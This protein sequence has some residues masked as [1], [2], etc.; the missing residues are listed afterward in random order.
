MAIVSSIVADGYR[1]LQGPIEGTQTVDPTVMLMTILGLV[2]RCWKVDSQLRNL[3]ADLERDTLSPL[4]WPELSSTEIESL[5]DDPKFGKVF[6]VS[7]KFSNIR[8][9]HICMLYWAITAILWSG[10]AYVYRLLAAVDAMNSLTTAD[11][12]TH[13]DTAAEKTGSQFDI[14]QLPPLEHRTD[15]ASLAR[16]ICQSIEY[17][18][19]SD[20]PDMAARAAVFPLKVAIESLHNAPGCERELVWAQAAMTRINESGVRLMNHL[21]V[22]MTDRSFLPG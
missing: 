9:A 8:T 19:D 14:T 5:D 16:S 21:P 6:P 13:D 22:P 20:Q 12:F 17:C 2:N 1:M 7:F 11:H 4:Y 15:V 3:Y 10:M 18:L